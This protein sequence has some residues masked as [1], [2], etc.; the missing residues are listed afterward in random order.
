MRAVFFEESYCMPHGTIVILVLKIA[1][2]AVT[3]LLLASL[4]VLARGNI[5]LHGRINTVFFFLTMITVL[6]FEGLIR[7]GPWI[8]TGWSATHGWSEDHHLAL[9]IHLCFTLPL[10]LI[11]PAMLY[12]GWKHQ[13][14]LHIALAVVFSI[15]WAGMFGSGV[16][17]LPH[18]L[19]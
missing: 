14:R 10:M 9:F 18:Q 8:E 16:F 3:L 17:Y 2:I 19:P 7:V 6:I 12:T 11:L 13:R 4:V 5:R 15:L 1:V